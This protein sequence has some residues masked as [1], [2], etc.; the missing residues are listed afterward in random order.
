MINQK[1][2]VQNFLKSPPTLNIDRLDS[3]PF[4]ELKDITKKYYHFSDT[5]QKKYKKLK[6]EFNSLLSSYND[7]KDQ[8]NEICYI[9]INLNNNIMQSALKNDFSIVFKQSLNLVLDD[10][11]ITDKNFID[12]KKNFEKDFRSLRNYL[13]KSEMD[14]KERLKNEKDVNNIKNQIAEMKKSFENEFK[15]IYPL[16]MKLTR[17]SENFIKNLQKLYYNLVNK[18]EEDLLSDYKFDELLL[19]SKNGFDELLYSASKFKNTSTKTKSELKLL[20]KKMKEVNSDY[21]KIKKKNQKQIRKN[22]KLKRNLNDMEKEHLSEMQ[23]FKEE[24]LIKDLQKEKYNLTVELQEEKSKS[25]LKDTEIF[26]FKNSNQDLVIKLNYLETEKIC[27]LRKEGFKL[28]QTLRDVKILQNKNKDLQNLLKSLN[29]K[30]EKLYKKNEQLQNSNIKFIESINDTK[31]TKFD[32]KTNSDFFGS[33]SEIKNPNNPKKQI[34]NFNPKILALELQIETER[35]VFDELM[36][37]KAIKID[38]LKKQIKFCN[39]KISIITKKSKSE[40]KELSRMS[41]ML[42]D[43]ES[44][45]FNEK[46]NNSINLPSIKRN[47]L[48]R[49]FTEP[50]E[51][52][53][54]DLVSY[55]KIYMQ[56]KDVYKTFVVIVSDDK[57]ERFYDLEKKINDTLELVSFYLN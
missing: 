57:D 3:Y 46:F 9:N 35:Q 21:E 47:N 5:L 18:N 40:K 20:Q 15:K 28:Q 12:Q 29:I 31:A 13:K 30:F 43:N 45:L 14:I 17:F 26:K 22:E 38:E 49:K 4:E 39:E 34:S 27:L 2:G 56:L 8:N 11:G 55:N 36:Q 7:L 44:L 52:S 23:N 50:N 1:K 10:I 48:F 19:I 41:S 25:F 42:L 32:L 16:L 33:N 54:N 6:E 37:D 24:E 53:R 51:D